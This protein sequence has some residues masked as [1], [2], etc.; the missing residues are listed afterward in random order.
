MKEELINNLGY[1]PEFIAKL[2]PAEVSLI[3]QHQVRDASTETIARLVQ[4]HKEQQRERERERQILQE[5][6]EFED[7]PTQLQA[8][9]RIATNAPP[10]AQERIVNSKDAD[11]DSSHRVP[12]LSNFASPR[13]FYGSP[14]SSSSSVATSPSSPRTWFELVERNSESGERIVLGLYATPKEAEESLET[15]QFFARRNNRRKV[16]FEV[17]QS[18]R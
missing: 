3:L 4:T 7:D 8:Q 6:Q 11:S 10:T 15:H 18:I 13:K 5:Q 2:K 14:M 1:S 16:D 12:I 9:D 17:R